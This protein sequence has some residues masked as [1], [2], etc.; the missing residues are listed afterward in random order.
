[1]RIRT[2]LRAAWSDVPVRP[3]MRPR[4]ASAPAPG[5]IGCLR[6]ATPRPFPRCAARPTGCRPPPPRAQPGAGRFW[7]AV[8]A[9]SYSRRVIIS[10]RRASTV[11]A[12]VVLTGIVIAAAFVPPAVS[13]WLG[14]AA[15]ALV[16][17]PLGVD[18]T[19]PAAVAV[20]HLGLIA[21]CFA[22]GVHD[23]HRAV[24]CTLLATFAVLPLAWAVRR[25]RRAS[26]AAAGMV[27]ALLTFGVF[28]WSTEQ[29]DAGPLS[30]IPQTLLLATTAGIVL[31]VQALRPA[32]PPSSPVPI[33]P[34]PPARPARPPWSRDVTNM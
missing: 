28:A 24:W 19:N 33:V 14:V 21:S 6:H 9:P 7:S 3:G 34:P 10:H 5:T 12:A 30:V 25:W 29:L 2:R 16:L 13:S 20:G 4:D 15:L 17:W 1:M 27:L 31:I 22:L 8:S 18:V 26:K 11:V 32:K 23:E